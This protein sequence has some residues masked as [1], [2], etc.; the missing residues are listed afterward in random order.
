MLHNSQQ[1]EACSDSS[2]YIRLYHIIIQ[3]TTLTVHL[4]C[5]T[6]CTHEQSYISKVIELGTLSLNLSHLYVWVPV[7]VHVCMREACVQVCMHV[8]VCVCA[9][10]HVQACNYIC[11]FVQPHLIHICS[12]ASSSD[13]CHILVSDGIVG[14]HYNGPVSLLW[15]CQ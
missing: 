11:A 13:L 3:Q 5:L 2:G 8:Y 15:L 1:T 14:P 7:S 6:K 4:R 10:V 9:H 12:W